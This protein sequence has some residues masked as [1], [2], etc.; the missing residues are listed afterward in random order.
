MK[1][2]SELLE[3]SNR[4]RIDLLF[5]EIQ[6]ARACLDA[7]R[8]TSQA[9]ARLRGQTVAREIYDAILHLLPC[10]SFSDGQRARAEREIAALKSRL[11]KAGAF[12]TA[13]EGTGPEEHN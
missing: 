4:L 8:V 12:L 7:A 3:D 1:S 13:E 5:T 6:T 11:E 2:L 9:E 10:T